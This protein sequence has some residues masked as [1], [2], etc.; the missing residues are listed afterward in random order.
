[1]RQANPAWKVALAVLSLLLTVLVWARGLE[2]S[3]D[4][5]SV[6]PKLSLHQ[7]EIALLAAPAL[8]EPLKP[9]LVGAEPENQ[10]R[11]TLR[12]ISLEKMQDRERLLLASL[13]S[14]ESP[15]RT[16]LTPELQDEKFLPLKQMLLGEFSE[17]NVLENKFSQ[18]A[19]LKNDPLLFRLSC[20]A[21]G[22]ESDFCIDDNV[23]Q[24]RALRLSIS[25]LIPSFAVLLG[26]ALFLRQAWIY[27]RK[28][29]SPWPKL[30]NLPLSLIDMVLLVAGG[31]VVMGEVIF[32]S[33]VAPI[34]QLLIGHVESPIGDSLKVLIGYSAMTIP[35]LLILRRQLN[36]LKGLDIP[37]GGW[38]QWRVFPLGKALISAIQGWLIIMPMVLLISWLANL[39][40]GDQGGSNPLLELVLQSHNNLALSLLLLT[41][42]VLAPLFEEVIFRGALL[43]VLANELGYGFGVMASA[44]VFAVAHLSVGELPALCVLGIGLGLLR[45][46]SGRLLPCV[47]MHSLWNGVTFASLLLLNG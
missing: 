10:L 23:S 15:R 31:F 1:M 13:E 5:P 39:L 43:P 3:F 44:L 6:T 36:G 30:Q 40:V 37:P 4:R 26:S 33:F 12:K 34:S 8:P 38:L 22:G 47:L 14:S 20:L 46:S 45:L 18:L 27:L 2:E 29:S 32:P 35:P 24:G 11:K 9:L 21:L 7:Q 19:I 41:T 25:Q 16:L 42:V 28:A 17:R